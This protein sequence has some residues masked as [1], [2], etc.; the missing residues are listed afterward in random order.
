MSAKVDPERRSFYYFSYPPT[1][2]IDPKDSFDSSKYPISPYRVVYDLLRDRVDERNRLLVTPYITQSSKGKRRTFKHYFGDD[3][4]Y[5][6][7]CEGSL[8]E[9]IDDRRIRYI[10]FAG[11]DPRQLTRE[12]LCYGLRKDQYTLEKEWELLGSFLVE[13]AYRSIRAPSNSDDFFLFE[14]SGK[15]P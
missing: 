12:P 14:A 15:R 8:E 3:A 5:I 7:D 4:V 11:M 13:N 6:E 10:I 1:V 2:P 9:F